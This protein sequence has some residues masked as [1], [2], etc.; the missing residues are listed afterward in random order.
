MASKAP[1]LPIALTDVT[2][3]SGRDGSVMSTTLTSASVNPPMSTRDP[4]AAVKAKVSPSA[5]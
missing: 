3:S 5:A 2:S 4:P 1:A